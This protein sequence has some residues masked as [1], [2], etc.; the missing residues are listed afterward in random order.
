MGQSLPWRSHRQYVSCVSHHATE[1]MSMRLIGYRERTRLVWAAFGSQC[2]M[3]GYH[4][5]RPPHQCS[6][7]HGWGGPRPGAG[8]WG[9]R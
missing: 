3:G 5:P 9:H 1:F 2:G 7:R 6:Q 4:S 8:R